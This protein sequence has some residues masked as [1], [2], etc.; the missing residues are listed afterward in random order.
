MAVWKAGEGAPDYGLSAIRQHQS[1][2]PRVASC[3]CAGM[4]R[5]ECR[6]SGLDD[7]NGCS[8]AFGRDCKGGSCTA[9]WRRSS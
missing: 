2:A 6:V 9:Q 8:A 1:F 7:A 4:H 5:Q 3:L